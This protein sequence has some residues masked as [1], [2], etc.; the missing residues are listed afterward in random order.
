MHCL[1]AYRF[2]TPILCFRIGVVS[3]LPL[4]VKIGGSIWPGIASL[5]PGGVTVCLGQVKIRGPVWPG[6]LGI[7]SLDP[8]GVTVCLDRVE[9]G[10]SI[11]PGCLGIV[12]LDPRGV[13]VCL[14]R[15][16]VGWSIW[17]GRLGIVSLLPAGSVFLGDVEIALDWECLHHSNSRQS[18]ESS[19][20]FHGK[21]DV[22]VGVD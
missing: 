20:E 22:N 5:D 18:N 14:D 15:V 2:H 6:C 12:S 1:M 11:W 10:W 7:T 19:G 13:T 8:R 16:E 9:V 3:L 4:G 17:P 21:S